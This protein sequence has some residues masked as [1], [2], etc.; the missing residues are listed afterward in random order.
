MI[1]YMLN[2]LI[3]CV[4]VHVEKLSNW[5]EAVVYLLV[6]LLVLWKPQGLFGKK[7]VKKV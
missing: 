1:I 2:V 5:K 4:C 3:G 6:M 7:M